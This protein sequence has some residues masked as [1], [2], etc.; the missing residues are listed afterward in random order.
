M[1]V[2]WKDIDRGG[3]AD[4]FH[5]VDRDNC[6]LLAKRIQNIMKQ[7]DT[8]SEKREIQKIVGK[9]TKVHI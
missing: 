7:P 4:Y 3:E 1:I 9:E 5:K 6:H 8:S 2:T